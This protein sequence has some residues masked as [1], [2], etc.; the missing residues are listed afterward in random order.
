MD[1][2]TGDVGRFAKKVDISA[3]LG[4]IAVAAQAGL[5]MAPPAYAQQSG[6]ETDLGVGAII[7]TAQK[8]DVTSAET[9][10]TASIISKAMVESL[11]LVSY[12]KL[13]R[14]VPGFQFERSTGNFQIVTIR[15]VGT[16]ATGQTF[17]PSVSPYINGIYAGGHPRDFSWPIYDVE[18]IEVIKG[19]QGGVSGQ[20]T[21]I[22]QI[23]VVTTMPGDD[24]EGYAKASREFVNEGW[25]AEG[26][27]TIPLT[28]NFSVRAAGAYQ[29]IGGWVRNLSTGHDLGETENISARL[30]AVWEPTTDL[31][32]TFF[33]EYNETFSLQPP[34]IYVQDPTGAYTNYAAPIYAWR[35]NRP[36]TAQLGHRS[37]SG[38][39]GN[40]KAHGFRGSVT[41][42]WDFG[43]DFRLTSITSGED[44]TDFTFIDLDFSHADIPTAADPRLGQ[45]I[46]QNWDYSQFTQELRLASPSDRP[47]SFV[48][49]AWYRHGDSNKLSNFFQDNAANDFYSAPIAYDMDIDNY[50]VYGDLNYRLSDDWTVGGSLRGTYESKKVTLSNTRSTWP[51]LYV[52][53][54][55]RT[56]E[57]SPTL[58]DGS[59]RVQYTPSNRWN[60]YALYS[61]GSKTGAVYDVVA[62]GVISTLKPEVAQTYEAGV[63]YSS[64]SLFASLAGFALDVSNYQ[65]TSSIVSNGV[66]TFTPNARDLAVRGIEGQAI[67]NAT[68]W[69]EF[70][71]GAMWLPTAK[72]ETLGGRNTRSPKWSLTGGAR[73]EATLAP[74]L[75]GALFAN[76]VHKTSFLMFPTGN[77]SRSFVTPGYT[78]L[79]IG[80]ELRLNDRVS[81][82]LLCSNCTNEYAWLNVNR[83]NI[84]GNGAFTA[85]LPPLRTVQLELGVEF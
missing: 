74:S 72:D 81:A 52:P 19:T 13:T 15:G 48:V 85:A 32:L 22:G 75:E 77:A 26:A 43:S 3:R 49:G 39:D 2:F 69:L 59:V 67:W 51:T 4:L 45:S 38:G 9:P 31:S 46:V 8:R 28:S 78:M 76:V 21:S 37:L 73:L 47:L 44:L 84:F 20:N 71:A 79:D 50:A 65:D 17:E 34:F 62:N 56:I 70:N 57:L 54:P 61:H 53:F 10:A 60:I 83:Q 23:Q 16:T 12:D 42:D 64:R 5:L 6:D 58:L 63:K 68:R 11:N 55:E 27:V 24:F 82:K 80:A 29:D 40:A 1:K 7:V 14:V 41:V 30:T 25:S 33:G 66:F 36:F 35:S 18:Q